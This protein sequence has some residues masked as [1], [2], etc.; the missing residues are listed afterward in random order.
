MSKL[1]SFIDFL[2]S[3]V[4]GAIAFIKQLWHIVTTVPPILYSLFNLAP[5]VLQI[6]FLIF[7]SLAIVLFVW[8]LIP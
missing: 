5:P 7:L 1:F 3:L 8:R 6:F 4:E 2:V